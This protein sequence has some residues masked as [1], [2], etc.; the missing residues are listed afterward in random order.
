MNCPYLNLSAI[1]TSLQNWMLLMM[2][3][4][5]ALMVYSPPTMLD[6]WLVDGH[7]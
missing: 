5:L 1:L 6:Y 4:Q 3:T 2:D 7:K